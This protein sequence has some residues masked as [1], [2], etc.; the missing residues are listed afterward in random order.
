MHPHPEIHR[1]LAHD[2]QRRRIAEAGAARAGRRR[3]GLRALLA[4]LA[5]SGGDPAREPLLARLA[6]DVVRQ[7]GVGRR[8]DPPAQHP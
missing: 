6:P 4:G 8:Q 7:L 2:V 3:G 1:E 5:S